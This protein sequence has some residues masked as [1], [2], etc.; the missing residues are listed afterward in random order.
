MW[1]F[2]L[3]IK[4]SLTCFA[5]TMKI[6]IILCLISM[7]GGG[8]FGDP[9]GLTHWGWV[10]HIFVSEI[11]IIGSD[12]GSSP[13]RRQAIIWT[14]AGILLIGPLGINF[15]EIWIETNA[16]SFNKMHLKMS[17]AKWRIFRLGL[18]VLRVSSLNNGIPILIKDLYVATTQT[19]IWSYPFTVPQPY[20][21]HAH[22]LIVLC[23]ICKMWEKKIHI[24]D[25]E[26]SYW[27]SSAF[28]LEF[29]LLLTFHKP[30]D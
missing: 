24:D 1:D 11:M 7:F 18:N 9:H 14:N 25:T 16:V 4:N 13:G 20:W 10:T 8:A 29:Y 3:W 21:R 27:S 6:P 2:P 23:G 5:W 12:N 19:W 28:I 26:S 15:S 17:S 22:P 30:M